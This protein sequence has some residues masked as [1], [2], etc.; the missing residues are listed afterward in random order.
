MMHTFGRIRWV[1]IQYHLLGEAS[2]RSPAFDM[3][4]MSWLQKKFGLST[5][6]VVLL[7]LRTAIFFLYW[8]T[9]NGRY[10]WW[11]DRAHYLHG[12]F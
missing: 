1:C 10:V 11:T 5:I 12:H 3:A 8:G 9:E 2:W 7:V 4:L 6:S